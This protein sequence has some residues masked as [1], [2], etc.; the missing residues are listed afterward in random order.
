MENSK[1]ALQNSTAA[2]PSLTV[3][4]Q[5]SGVAPQNSI[6]VLPDGAWLATGS[7]DETIKLWNPET[8]TCF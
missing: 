2:L 3:S 6:A 8:G 7:V 1:A 4:S 5:N